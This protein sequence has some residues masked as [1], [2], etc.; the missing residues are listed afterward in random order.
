MRRAFLPIRLVSLALCIGAVTAGSASASTIAP[1]SNLGELARISRTVVLAQAAGSQSELRGKVPYTLTAFDVV[2]QVAGAAV[3]SRIQVETPGGEVGDVG[4]A[5]AGAPR[6]QTG[7]RYLLFLDDARN[8]NWRP[9]MLSYGILREEKGGLMSPVPEAS[10]LHV[11]QR[12]GVEGVGA[13][14]EADLLAH[15]KATAA[16]APWHAQAVEASP[17]Q[18]AQLAQSKAVA[19]PADT[20][21]MA[22]A[23]LYQPPQN[24]AFLNDAD[25]HPLRWFDFE[26]TG[27]TSLWH[28]TPG[29]VGISDGGVAAVQNAT[30]AWTNDPNSIIKLN[31]A[32]SKGSSSTCASGAADVAGEVTFND[33]CNQIPPLAVCSGTLPP[34][35]SS[36][37]CGT[38]AVYGN[39]YSKTSRFYDTV[40]WYPLTG[41]SI[42]V[43]NGSQCLGETD[44]QEMM[45][46]YVGHGLG[47]GHHNDQN[48]TMY[49]QL[50]V[51][52]PRGATIAKTDS[53]CASYLYHTFQ[54]VPFYHW[55]WQ[56][57]EALDNAHITTGCTTGQFCPVDS[58]LRAEMAAFIERA[59]HGGSYVPPPA[60]GTVYDD[61]PASYWAAGYIEQATAEGIP[62]TCGVRKYCPGDLLMRADM[63]LFLLR[64]KHG[65]SYV[66]PKGTG[67]LFDDVPASYWAVDWIEELYNEHITTGCAPRQYCPD[68]PVQRGEMAAFLVRT[69]GLAV[70]PVN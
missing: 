3:K 21:A 44:F 39:F 46:H 22:G 48:A 29:Q 2:Q 6:F 63:A 67:T 25:G 62:T 70:P 66:P 15:L 23:A 52:P 60:T 13:Y 56:N 11:V 49:S 43:N 50:G 18:L 5:V 8:G 55:A 1:P 54:D 20:K 17:S 28:T 4:F 61:V 9:K 59:I 31:Y 24:C 69:F 36:T 58:V 65:G 68:R 32:G 53:I 42:V 35:W 41:M 12:P 14:R 51:H 19:Q 57:V 38:V 7:E 30:A 34:G 37:C 27:S 33:P 26:T 45:T 16:G 64:A 10:E 40:D 47:F